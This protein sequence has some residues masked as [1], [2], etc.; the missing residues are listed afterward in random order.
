M[1]ALTRIAAPAASAM[2]AAACASGCA[3]TGDDEPPADLAGCYYFER[4][5]AADQLRLPWGVRLLDRPLEGWP[6]IQQ[7]V[8]VRVATTLTADG[9][10]DHP[11][12]YWRPMGQDSINIGYPAG[13]GL[14]LRLAVEPA[15]LAGTAR[16]VGDALPL[17]GVAN[18]PLRTVSLTHARCPED[19]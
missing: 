2:I 15:R 3:S 17:D 6:A 10:V 13:G 19:A 5:A 7:L 4:D 12:G 9:D 14:S 18:R 1:T 16:P 8:G 11:F